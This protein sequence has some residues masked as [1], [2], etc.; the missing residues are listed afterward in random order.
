MFKEE[1][2][3]S[4]STTDDSLSHADIMLPSQYFGAMGSSGLSGE[5]RLM[6]AVLVDAIAG[7]RDMH[8]SEEGGD[9]SEHG[10][11]RDMLYRIC[12]QAPSMLASEDRVTERREGAVI[13]RLERK[14]R[15]AWPCC[16][17]ET[18]PGGE[19]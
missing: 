6:L 9:W 7:M 15:A 19:K 4:E 17:R 12:E 18:V 3:D 16:G 5:Q 14:L 1:M 8:D 10:Q 2:E 11:H 13:R